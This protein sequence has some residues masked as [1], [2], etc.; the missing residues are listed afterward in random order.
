MGRAA[1]TWQLR[2]CINRWSAAIPQPNDPAC[3]GDRRQRALL[4]RRSAEAGSADDSDSHRPTTQKG[5]IA[6][7]RSHR[8]DGTDSRR[9]VPTAA[10]AAKIIRAGARAT[11]DTRRAFGNLAL[12]CGGT[13]SSNPSPSSSESIANHFCGL[14]KPLDSLQVRS[15]ATIFRGADPGRDRRI[16]SGPRPVLRRPYVLVCRRDSA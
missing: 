11:R 8:Y 4:L 12:S 15:A 5:V 13:K 1:G 9:Q 7:H 6:M 3:A 16:T 2:R 10:Q 14:S